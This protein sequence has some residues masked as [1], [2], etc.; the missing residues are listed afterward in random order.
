M[1]NERYEIAIFTFHPNDI[2]EFDTDT[3]F[4]NIYNYWCFLSL[5]TNILFMG[6]L[7]KTKTKRQYC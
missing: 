5:S 7:R 4:I 2:D 6:K 3:L 1:D